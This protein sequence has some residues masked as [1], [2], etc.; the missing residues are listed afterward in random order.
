[1]TIKCALCANAMSAVCVFGLKLKVAAQARF[2]CLVL[3]DRLELEAAAVDC[4]QP[5]IPAT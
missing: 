3:H 1:M 2:P 5:A 4:G